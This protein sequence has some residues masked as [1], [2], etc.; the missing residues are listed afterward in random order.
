MLR[1]SIE[2]EC[3]DCE[4]CGGFITVPP[5]LYAKLGLPSE[6]TRSKCETCNGEGII[7]ATRKVTDGQP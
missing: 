6:C 3:P 1:N 4:G 5:V 2:T 7:V